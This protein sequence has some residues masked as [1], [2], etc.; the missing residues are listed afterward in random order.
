[1]LVGGGGF[2]GIAFGEGMAAI[3]L[4]RRRKPAAAFSDIHLPDISDLVLSQRLREILGS[5]AP[6]IVLSG[7]GSMEVLNSLPH[8]G[9]THFFQKPVSATLLL[10]H[11]RGHFPQRQ[12]ETGT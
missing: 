10:D 5:A 2:E 6:I 8:V 4:G 12:A 3:E 7:D 9:A 1:M 11:F